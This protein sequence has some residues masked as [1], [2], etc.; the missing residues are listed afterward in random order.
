MIGVVSVSDYLQAVHDGADL[1]SLDAALKPLCREPFRRIDR[2][3]QLALLGSARCAT[4]QTLQADCA[5][6]ISSGLGPIGNNIVI[7]KH[8]IHDCEIP[9]P[10]NF[11][12]TLGSAAGYY[13]ARNLGLNGQNLFISR[14]G[15]SLQ[16]A[17]SMAMA[18]MTL[19]IV[20]QALVGSVEEAVL[21][22]GEHRQ[23]QGLADDAPVVEGSH[24][25]LLQADAGTG[26]SVQ[27]TRFESFDALT[28]SI[29]ASWQEG[30]RLHC[31][32]GTQPEL[33]RRL[34][35]AFP[36]SESD[37]IDGSHDDPDAIWLARSLKVNDSTGLF[38]GGGT[39][40]TG[41]TLF[42]FGTHTDP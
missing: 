29:R 19:G 32:V 17:L 30:D 24:W 12:N 36:D 2:F 37:V 10:F 16:A 18:D 21:P 22:L 23:R 33:V 7:Q 13:V 11:I 4:G 31:A 1:P 40:E 15:A 35:Q 3:I 20:S 39:N 8:L 6:Y 42:H 38:L 9:K 27:H 26:R 41:W 25:L 5:V 28:A 34:N 14:R